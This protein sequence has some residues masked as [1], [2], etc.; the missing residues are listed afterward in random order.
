M[1]WQ[2]VFEQ[3]KGNVTVA[4]CGQGADELHAGYSRYRV[5]R[6]LKCCQI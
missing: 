1:F 5:N 4:L 2:S 6:A 3:M